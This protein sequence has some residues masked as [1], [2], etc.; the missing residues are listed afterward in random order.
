MAR[1]AATESPF[2]AV[3]SSTRRRLLDLLKSGE[4]T[5]SELTDA[6]DVSQPAVSQHLAA[7]RGAGLVDE[8]RD[9]RF[10]FYRLT[11]EPLAEVFGWVKEYEAFWQA[12][13]DALGRV[14]DEMKK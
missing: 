8:R 9:G 1:A 3:A 6:L 13:L 12:R 4:K 11:P 10:R 14:L 2:T 5:V 7:L